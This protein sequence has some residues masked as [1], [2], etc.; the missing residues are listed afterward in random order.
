M[1]YIAA[2]LLI[3][4]TLILISYIGV[5]VFEGAEA[6]FLEIE[7]GILNVGFMI[8]FAVSTLAGWLAVLFSV[9][10]RDNN[11]ITLV[12]KGVSLG[13]LTW[14]WVFV[15]LFFAERIALAAC[16]LSG[17]VG[18]LTLAMPALSDSS[19]QRLPAFG[20]VALMASFPIVVSPLL[21][22]DPQP[23]GL[24]EANWGVYHPDYEVEEGEEFVAHYQEHGRRFNKQAR[25]IISKTTMFM[26]NLLGQPLSNT[27]N[28]CDY[29][30][31]YA[32]F[33]SSFGDGCASQKSNNRGT[34][35]E[36]EFYEPGKLRCMNC[37]KFGKPKHWVMVQ[38]LRQWYSSM[39]PPIPYPE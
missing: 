9:P 20:L 12:G 18:L 4:S 23:D 15:W 27:F 8:V 35:L 38:S 5:S 32:L 13:F 24:K 17:W 37:R 14:P 7:N 30:D 6:S 19:N 22:A 2:F 25:L 10:F 26:A 36:I 21:W 16:L 28:F 34:L 31:N 29:N 1:Q 3:P 33:M 11:R 39:E